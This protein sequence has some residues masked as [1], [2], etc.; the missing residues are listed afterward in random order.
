MDD[1][2][3]PRLSL[4]LIDFYDELTAESNKATNDAFHYIFLS[5]KKNRRRELVNE[6]ALIFA[7]QERW[8]FSVVDPGDYSYEDQINIFSNCRLMIGSHG[9]GFT[10]LLF[11]EPTATIIEL[12]P[13]KYLNVGLQRIAI[14]KG[15][16]YHYIVGDT[17]R[18]NAKNAHLLKYTINIDKVLE[19]LEFFF[20]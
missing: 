17:L 10:N 7:I 11:A 5:R 2:L 9:A 8:N 19:K 4:R 16:D 12:F 18:Y 15:L 1:W 14:A 20:G 13:D 6:K 3:Y